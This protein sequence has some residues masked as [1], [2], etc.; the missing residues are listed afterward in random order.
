VIR[1]DQWRALLVGEERVADPRVVPLPVKAQAVLRETV[2][3]VEFAGYAGAEGGGHGRAAIFG[4]SVFDRQARKWAAFS[5]GAPAT[6]G[7]SLNAVP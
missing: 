4:A 3:A 6:T 7:I 5:H 1:T 2:F